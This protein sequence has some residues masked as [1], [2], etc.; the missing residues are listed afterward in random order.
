[1]EDRVTVDEPLISTDVD[2]LIRTVSERQK[3]SLVDLRLACNIDKKTLDKWLA[4]LEEEGYISI[5][6]NLGATYVVWN[7][8]TASPPSQIPSPGQLQIPAPEAPSPSEDQSLLPAEVQPA[9]HL[10]SPLQEEQKPMEKPMEET[11]IATPSIKVTP[12]DQEPEELLSQYLAR[13]RENRAPED[14]KASILTSMSDQSGSHPQNFSSSDSD[15]SSSNSST[16]ASQFVSDDSTIDR[17]LDETVDREL[18]TQI[19]QKTFSAPTIRSTE[20]KDDGRELL[21]SYVREINQEKAEIEKLKQAK[22]SLYQNKLASI[23]RKAE[24]DLVNLTESILEK[25]SKI[26]E[27]KEKVLELPDKIDELQKVQDQ[28]NRLRTDSRVTLENAKEKVSEFLDRIENSKIDLDG[29]I[30][31][32]KN[33]LESETSK[34]SQLQSITASADSQIETLNSAMEQAHSQVETL[35]RTIYDLNSNL[36][37]ISETKDSAS[38]ALSDLKSGVSMHGEELSSLE[39]ELENISRVEHWIKEYLTDYEK[40][41]DQIEDYVAK[42]DDE[43]AELKESA[44]SVYLDKYLTELESISDTYQGELDDAVSQEKD[45]DKSIV[46]SK[47]RIMKLV[48]DSKDLV[49]KLRGEGSSGRNFDSIS[50]MIKEKAK[51]L[52]GLVE[53]KERERGKLVED[54]KD[55]RKTKSSSRKPFVGTKKNKGKKK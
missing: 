5:E 20:K 18:P 29:Q 36:K 15:F 48:K 41:V 35:N 17:V 2:R 43:L 11:S 8:E 39:S 54:S 26:S 14:L 4:V 38:A 45:I 33:I 47:T 51:K 46:Q 25:Q 53:E 52:K 16:S 23:E 49:R 13:K 55:A 50:A 9:D 12:F 34:L 6:Y 31:R 22:N 19:P 27:L 32:L 30:A 1:M 21:N 40:K 42:S 44:E 24:A 7:G 3:I 37:K 28:M 10:E